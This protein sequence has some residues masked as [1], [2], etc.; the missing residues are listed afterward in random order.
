MR[1]PCSGGVRSRGESRLV[2]MPYSS[3]FVAS[4]TCGADGYAELMKTTAGSCTAIESISGATL[5]FMKATVTPSMVTFC[6]GFGICRRHWTYCAAGA[7]TL[8][9]S[10]VCAVVHGLHVASGVRVLPLR[11]ETATVPGSRLRQIGR[12]SCREGGGGAGGG[13]V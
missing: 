13:G 12:A 10:E 9:S 5:R 8:P 3:G 2:K 7:L 6:V 11:N 4:T 1:L